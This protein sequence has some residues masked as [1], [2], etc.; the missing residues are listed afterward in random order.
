MKP[1]DAFLHSV[2]TAFRAEDGADG[3]VWAWAV[4]AVSVL[5]A[6]LII[7]RMRAQRQARRAGE[8]A[9]ARLAADKNLTATDQALIQ[10]L[11]ARAAA[12]PLVVGTHL[13]VFERATAALLGAAAAPAA[14]APVEGLFAEVARLRRT[15]G[16]H[17][18]PEQFPLLST[19]ELVSGVRV[20][21]GG[22]AGMVGEVN[23][24]WFD[25]ECSAEA[26]FSAAVDQTVRVAFVRGGEARYVARCA[27]AAAIPAHAPRQLFLRHDERPERTQKRNA[28]RVTVRGEIHLR[29]RPAEASPTEGMRDEGVT[30]GELVDLSI[31]GMAIAVESKLAVGTS[32]RASFDWE[33]NAYADL[34]VV[35]LQCEARSRNVHIARL[36]FRGLGVADENRLAAA[37]A[38]R[39]AH[40]S[41][42]GDGNGEGKTDAS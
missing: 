23:E 14:G 9:F 21:V 24:A 37:I 15:L 42:A 31:G 4:L 30:H 17:V 22:V 28:V 34:P 1:V 39:S 18:L 41:P 40:A 19:R 7:T 36:Q 38:R 32:L 33:G 29:A 12:E 27:V 5:A 8:A 26:V 10:R 13:D 11:A 6:V 25:V 16:F 20:D 3:A 35:V 2:R